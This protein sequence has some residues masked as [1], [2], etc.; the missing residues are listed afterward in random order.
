MYKALKTRIYP[1]D[2][3]KA[4][5]E[6]TFGCARFIYNEFLTRQIERHDYDQHC[7]GKYEMHHWVTEI[8]KEKCWL[9][10]VDSRALIVSAS[11]LDM[12]YKK[13]F[14]GSGFPRYKSKRDSN[15]SYS[16]TQNMFVESHFIR[17]PKIGRIHTY[18]R[19]DYTIK[20]KSI[21]ISRK[22]GLYF[23]SIQYNDGKE[24]SEPNGNPVIGIDIGIKD[25]AILSD[26]TKIPNPQHTKK[27]EKKIKKL[28]REL[29]RKKNG[30]NRRKEAKRKLARAQMDL[31]NC[32]KDYLHKA[33]TMITKSYGYIAIEDLAVSNMVM[34]HKLA[35]AISDCGWGEFRRQLEYKAKWYGSE[36]RVI[37]RFEPSSKTCSACGS[38][39]KELTLKDREW[40]CADCGTMHD[41]DINAAKNILAFSYAPT[42]SREVGVEGDTNL[43]KQASEEASNK[44]K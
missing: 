25:L 27:H 38:I 19:L 17:V 11:N 43:C 1:T 5:I 34:N 8:K 16:T 32:R 36:V 21:I 24:P 10:E 35:G 30:S 39:N 2:E 6:K 33:T 3:Q 44:L 12:A 31:A 13:F 7:S 20:P 28:Q 9:R 40:I 26:G 23:A 22:A 37:G 18:E 29:S 41:R 15:Q 4:L 14:S 42:G